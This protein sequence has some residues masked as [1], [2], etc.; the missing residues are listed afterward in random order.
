MTSAYEKLAWNVL[1]NADITSSILMKGLSGSKPVSGNVE[2]VS[3]V[4]RHPYFRKATGLQGL[5]SRKIST[6]GEYSKVPVTLR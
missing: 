5:R 4:R 3:R 2:D 1:Q 6:F